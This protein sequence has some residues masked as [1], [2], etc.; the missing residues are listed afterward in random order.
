MI[1]ESQRGTAGNLH[2]ALKNMN[3]IN[4]RKLLI[5]SFLREDGTLEAGNWRIKDTSALSVVKLSRSV[6]QAVTRPFSIS[7]SMYYRL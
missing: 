6:Y 5:D 3:S 2:G 7:V 4:A 1:Y